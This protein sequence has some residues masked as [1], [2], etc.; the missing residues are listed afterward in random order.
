MPWPPLFYA[1]RHA[2][3]GMPYV[4]AP[5]V[6]KYKNRD[7]YYF[8]SGPSLSLMRNWQI[9]QEVAVRYVRRFKPMAYRASEIN[10]ALRRRYGN[11]ADPIPCIGLGY[12]IIDKRAYRQSRIAATIEFINI[13]T[14]DKRPEVLSACHARDDRIR[15][16]RSKKKP[17]TGHEL[18]IRVALIELEE[19]IYAKTRIY[20]KKG[21]RTE[22]PG[23]TNRVA[24]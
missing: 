11:K 15:L 9:A 23:G 19:L 22:K 10:M 18:D 12:L 6:E 5:G 17:I 20:G 13:Q 14:F 7:E 3:V 8:N 24:R 4:H 16:L 2:L 21:Y 1:F